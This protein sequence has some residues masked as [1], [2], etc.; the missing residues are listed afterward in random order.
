V[1][2]D[3]G[4][5]GRHRGTGGMKRTGLPIPAVSIGTVRHRSNGLASCRS[6]DGD[7]CGV[8]GGAADGQDQLV[9]SSGEVGQLDVRLR[10]P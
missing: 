1:A 8:A 5:A 10:K 2:R 9:L 4:N 3:G 7:R 6:L